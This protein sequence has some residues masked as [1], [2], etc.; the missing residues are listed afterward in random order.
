MN[1]RKL[2]AA[3]IPVGIVQQITRNRN[4]HPCREGI[5]VHKRKNVPHTLLLLF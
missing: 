2:K 1:L 3:K 5:L 4:D